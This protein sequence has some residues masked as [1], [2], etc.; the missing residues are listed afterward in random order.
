[1]GVFCWKNES[2]LKLL[3]FFSTKNIGIF[4]KLTSDNLTKTVTNDVVSF[5]QLGPGF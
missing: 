2:A 1:M 5:E 4:Q 3:T